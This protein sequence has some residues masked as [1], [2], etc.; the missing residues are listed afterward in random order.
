MKLVLVFLLT[1][2]VAMALS[3]KESKDSDDYDVEE[4]ISNRRLLLPY[5]KCALDIGKCTSSGKDLKDHIRESLEKDCANCT[6]S[7]KKDSEL[8]FKHLINK[9]KDY[10]QQ[11]IK[12]YDP[13]RQY[14]PKYEKKYL[15]KA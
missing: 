11:L 5:I 2:S 10:W 3:V 8:V 9:E 15:G 14:A 7:Q 12:K 4:I 13:E 6:P 1:A